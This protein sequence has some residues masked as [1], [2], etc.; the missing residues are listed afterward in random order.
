MAIPKIIDD[1]EAR[2][3]D[4]GDTLTGD[5][6]FKKAENGK[7]KIY[8][9]HSN[10]MDYGL[11]LLDET[12]DGLNTARLVLCANPNRDNLAF[13]LNGTSYLLYGEH[14]K[15]LMKQFFLPLTGGSLTGAVMQTVN[16]NPYYGLNDGTNNWYFQAVKADNACYIGP[17]YDLALKI[18]TSGNMTVRGNITANTINVNTAIVPDVAGGANV[19]TGSLPFTQ[20]VARNYYLYS[21][22]AYQTG[23]FYNATTGTAETAGHAQLIIGNSTSTGSIGNAKGTIAIYGDLNYYASIGVKTGLTANRS[24]ILPDTSGTFA[25]MNTNIFVQKDLIYDLSPYSKGNP[26]YNLKTWMSSTGKIV[27]RPQSDGAQD[28]WLIPTQYDNVF[29]IAGLVV[30]GTQGNEYLWTMGPLLTNNKVIFHRRYDT[31]GTPKAAGGINGDRVLEYRHNPAGELD[32]SALLTV[33]A[34]ADINGICPVLG[35]GAAT[36]VAAGE[37]YSSFPTTAWSELG[38]SAASEQLF[39]VSD[40]ATKI[41][42]NCNTIANRV[43]TAE[44]SSNNS[45]FINARAKAFFQYDSSSDLYYE[46]RITRVNSSSPGAKTANILLWAW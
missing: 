2:V 46:G 7:S 43:M 14:N 19:G 35:G 45:N 26:D 25:T 20:T 39:L 4:T 37:A 15:D 42:T 16:G 12:Q 23:R 13:L 30:G 1:I 40:G 9:N 5:L 44:F 27:L 29:D 10:T 22:N 36:V 3:K 8:K 21:S 32:T 18:D 33:Y 17:G 28:V 24:F 34:P 11:Q 31:T 6:I 38:V 41:Y